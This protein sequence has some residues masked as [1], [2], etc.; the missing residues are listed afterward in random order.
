MWIPRP[1]SPTE[2]HIDF[3]PPH[4]K[5]FNKYPPNVFAKKAVEKGHRCGRFPRGQNGSVFGLLFGHGSIEV[6]L[7]LIDQLPEHTLLGAFGATFG[8]VWRDPGTEGK[9]IVQNGW[10]VSWKILSRNG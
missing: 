9:S 7:L 2:K 8:D 1:R 10:L 4:Q 3:P 5:M 6:L